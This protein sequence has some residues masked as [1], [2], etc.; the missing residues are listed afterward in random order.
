MPLHPADLSAH[1]YEEEVTLGLLENEEQL[2]QEASAALA[3]IEQGTF[4]I[5]E[6][7]R[8]PIAEKRLQALPYA[9]YC[10]PCAKQREG[11]TAP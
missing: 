4:G 6:A 11:P 3:R 7:C 5:C 1:D 9:R 8:Q 2:L 10:A